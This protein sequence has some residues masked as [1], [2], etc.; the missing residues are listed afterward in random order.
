MGL[1]GDGS[2]AMS[3]GDLATVARVGGPTVLILFNNG[4][5]GWIKAL[6]EFYH[7]GRYYSVDF[8][9]ELSY[10]GVAQGFGLRARQVTDPENI[11]S[12]LREA[13]DSGSPY[14]VEVIVAPEH[15]AVT[16]VA[17]WQRAEASRRTPN[18]T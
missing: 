1:C 2:F 9:E 3:A 8:D 12:A 16:P 14:L 17:P 15:E 7:G 11:G 5:Y 6:Q 18:V 10:T 4:S 13:L